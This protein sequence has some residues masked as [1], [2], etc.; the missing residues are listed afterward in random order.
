MGCSC[1]V[2]QRWAAPRALQYPQVLWDLQEEV[3]VP[4]PSSSWSCVF[5]ICL[6]LFI[7]PS[8]LLGLLYRLFFVEFQLKL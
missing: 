5:E 1:P 2:G 8:A 4:A 7:V 3:L 6:L